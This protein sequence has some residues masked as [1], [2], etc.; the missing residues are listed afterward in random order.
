MN[1]AF[2]GAPCEAIGPG[3][4]WLVTFWTIAACCISYTVG[5][6]SATRVAQSEDTL[7]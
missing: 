5:W 7:D 6:H 1:Y 3:L 4:G 2:H